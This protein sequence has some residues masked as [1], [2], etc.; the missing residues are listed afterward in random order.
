MDM[1]VLTEA[2]QEQLAAW[3]ATQQD[4][5]REANLPQL[6]AQQAHATPEAVALVAD[7]QALTYRDL[8]QRANQLAH[9]LQALGVGPNVLVGVCLERS[10]DLVVGLLAVLKAGGAYVP[11]DP[12]SPAERLAFLLQDAQTPVLLTQHALL[13]HLP[14]TGARLLCLDT[15]TALFAQQPRSDPSCAARLSDLA[16]VIYTS[17]STGWPKG[18]QINHNSLLNLLWWHRR[19]FAVTSADRATQLTSPA[20]DATGWELWPYLSCGAC[21]YLLDEEARVQPVACRDFLLAHQISISF[22]PTAMAEQVLRLDWPQQAAL[23]YLLTGADALQHYPSARLPF[24]LINNYGPTEAT[25]VATSGLVPALATGAQATRPPTIGRPIANTQVYLL[26]E[27]LQPVPPGSPGELYIGGVGVAAG[28]LRRPELTAERF[29]PHPWSAEPGARLYKTGDLARYLPDGQ[30]EFLGRLDYQIKLKGYRIEQGEIVAALSEHPAVQASAVLAREDAPGNKRLVAYVVVTPGVAVT[31]NR[32]R[33]RLAAR[34]PEYMLPACFVQLEALP[35][36][37]NG[38]L[39]RAALPAP[40]EATLLATEV[41]TVPS[42]PTEARLVELV[43]PLL[44]LEQLGVEEDIFLQ[45]GH[46]LLG[47]QLIARVAETFGVE[48]SLRTLFS[49]PSIRELAV[50]IE[51]VV[52]A[53][54]ASMSEEEALLLLQQGQSR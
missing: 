12:S 53:R 9:A 1:L 13:N 25:A 8:N 15:D 47:T 42:T 44:G 31:A 20:F 10:F 2:E 17:G 4:Y 51:R 41:T 6:V 54:L 22:L 29:L 46:S 50:E 52:R 43:A 37:A 49:K 27:Q 18:V 34:L 14:S 39:D 23:R 45:G 28:Y 36:T 24:A 30:L 19:A 35:T 40:E 5:P 26:D 32:L 11:L 7:G 38:K 3:N 16:C 48:L 21:V 33:A